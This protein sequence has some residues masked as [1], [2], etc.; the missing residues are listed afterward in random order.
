MNFDKIFG[1]ICIIFG[2]FVFFASLGIFILKIFMALLG[3]LLVIFGM[4]L[5]QTKPLE[6]DITRIWIRKFNDE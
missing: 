4:R 5:R 3:L 6:W 2:T 1:A